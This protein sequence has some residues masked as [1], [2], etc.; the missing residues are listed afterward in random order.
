MELVRE[1][2]IDSPPVSRSSTWLGNVGWKRHGLVAPDEM[3][4][5]AG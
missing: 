3:P 2:S 5:S 4:R 1:A